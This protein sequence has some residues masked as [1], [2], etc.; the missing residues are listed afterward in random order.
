MIKAFLRILCYLRG[1]EP[2]YYL[3]KPLTHGGEVWGIKC[4]T[5]GC[6]LKAD[7]KGQYWS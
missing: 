2:R 5:C 6:E 1:H 4:K 7:W 3:K